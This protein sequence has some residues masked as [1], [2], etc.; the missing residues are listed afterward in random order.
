M[1]SAVIQYN[2]GYNGISVHTDFLGTNTANGLKCDF[3]GN[4]DLLNHS[5]NLTWKFDWIGTPNSKKPDFWTGTIIVKSGSQHFTRSEYE[6][7]LSDEEMV[8]NKA[9]SG[10]PLTG[11]GAYFEYSL[12]PNYHE[13]EEEI[14]MNELFKP[15]EQHDAV[16]AIGQTKLHV[17]KAFLSYHSEFFKTLFSSKSTVNQ[18]R[19]IPIKDVAF[20]NFAL[21]LSS[22]YPNPVFPNDKT[23]EKLLEMSRRFSVSSV[24]G[25]VEYHLIHNSRIPNYK[26]IWLADEYKMTELLE[27]CVQNIDS[28]E[29]T[30]ELQKSPEY[31]KLSNDAKVMVLDRIMQFI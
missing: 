18:L 6:I 31:A 23:A 12:T 29:A 7:E 14:R 4:M 2:S 16:L 25:I 28:I 30:K 8:V 15:S 24:T 19:E 20:K 26:L 13:I 22:F 5:M 1:S 10:H 27:K 11:V 9:I 3:H 17:S 21:L